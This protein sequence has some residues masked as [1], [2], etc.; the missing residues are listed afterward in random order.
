VLQ[1]VGA[2]ALLVGTPGDNVTPEACNGVVVGGATRRARRINFAGDIVNL[3]GCHHT[4]T[5]LLGKSLRFLKH[6]VCDDQ[7]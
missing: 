3:P 1:G 4:D 5:V 2:L 6:Y 7:Q